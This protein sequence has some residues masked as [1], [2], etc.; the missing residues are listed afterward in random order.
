MEANYEWLEMVP[1]GEALATHAPLG[2][3]DLPTASYTEMMEWVLPTRVRQRY[4]AVQK[5]FSARPEVVSFLRGGSWRGF[6]RKYAESNLLHKKMLR[7]SARIAAV[8]MRHSS[9][10]ANDELVHARDLLLR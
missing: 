1:P 8:P 4:H 3:A 5:E 2:R 7:V 9:S 10:K 6:F